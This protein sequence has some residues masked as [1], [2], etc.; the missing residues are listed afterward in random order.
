MTQYYKGDENEQKMYLSIN[1][2]CQII[3]NSLTECFDGIYESVP[4]GQFIYDNK[5]VP[6]TN[7]IKRDVFASAFSE[8][9][10]AWQT[11]GTFES[12]L[13][14]FRKI[15]GENVDVE[16]TVPDPGKLQIEIDISS[17]GTE[18]SPW[19]AREIV[20]NS[21]VFHNVVD[22]VGD[23]IVFQTQLGVQSQSELEKILFTMVPNGIWTEISLIIS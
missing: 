7:A 23:Q 1:A 4:M 14:V 6:L 9:F 8:I 5:L 3:S 12:Y 20:D 2:I 15:F 22:D 18:L 10:D 16:F 19:V 13:L 21:Y 17:S 11:A